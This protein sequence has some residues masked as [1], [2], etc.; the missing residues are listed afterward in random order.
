MA[1][2]H[3]LPA[4]LLRDRE[5][6]NQPVETLLTASR[7][8]SGASA[9]TEIVRANMFEEKLRFLLQIVDQWIG[10]GGLGCSRV[11]DEQLQWNGLW[12]KDHAKK[13]D[14]VTVGR[15]GGDELR[16]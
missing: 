1:E 5:V 7:S 8:E 14:W 3:E 11:G 10:G 4:R 2:T 12:V 6:L 15:Y 16:A 9:L 13:V